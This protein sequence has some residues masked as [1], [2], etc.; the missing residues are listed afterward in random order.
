MGRLSRAE[1][2]PDDE[3]SVVHCINR[4]VRRGFLCGKDSVSGKNFEH[5]R[6]WIR[7]RF[8]FLAGQMAVEVLGYAVLSNHFHIVLRNRPD[9]VAEWSDDE[10]ALRW[11]NLCP[12]RRNKDKTPAK[13][14]QLELNAVKGDKEKLKEYRKRLS[15]VSWF[16]RFVA[17]H[18]AKRANE[19][20]EC[21]G[22]FWEGRFK[23]QPLLDDAAILACMQ[24]VDLNPIRAKIA[25]TVEGSDFTSGQDRL[26]DLK[27]GVSGD[28]I[29]V[30]GREALGSLPAA[31]NRDAF[32]R[33]CEHGERAGWLTPIS[34]EPPRQAV[35]YRKSKRRTSNKG[36]LNLSLVEYLQL[37]DWTGRQIRRDGKSGTIPSDLLSIF[38]RVGVSSE[39]WVECVKRFGKWHGSGVGRTSSLKQHA[40]R[41]GRN[42]SLNARRSRQLFG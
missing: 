30:S 37:L 40:E 27:D 32:D 21:T 33:Q 16:M 5:R 35:R 3:I 6:E 22:R 4:C 28:G 41:T 23:C 11:W 2:C 9:V 36:C 1:S 20:D 8:E 10:V 31:D 13:P 15:S 29:Q 26:A 24:Y 12:G 25:K 34:L 38:E 17:E 19:E 42:R 18:I 39:L 14:T 7:G